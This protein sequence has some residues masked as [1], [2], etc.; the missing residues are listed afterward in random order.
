MQILLTLAYDGTNYGGW[1]RQKNAVTVQQRLEEALESIFGD[2]IRAAGASRTDA[3]V[4]ALGQRASFFIEENRIPMGKLPIVINSYLPS[5]IAVSCAQQVP[6][7]FN[8]R[9]D[10]KEKTYEY[11]IWYAKFPNPLQRITSLFHPYE[12]D[13][14]EMKKAASAFVGEHD[15][16]AFCSA[17]TLVKSRVRKVFECRVDEAAPI[18][19]FTVRGDGFLYNMVRIIAGTLLYVGQGKI[20]AEDAPYIIESRNRALAGKTAPPQGLTLL[21]IK[22]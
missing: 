22:Y 10:A 21:E 14:G 13:V 1:Q 19:T 17:G 8:P 16:S 2:P 6:D 3:G 20:K 5:D 18:L 15:F 4:H 11:R 9:F 7:A 12:L